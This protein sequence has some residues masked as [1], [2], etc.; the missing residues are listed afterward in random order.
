MF[1]SSGG[2]KGYCVHGKGNAHTYMLDFTSYY[3]TT[4]F[5][6]FVD[7][8]S[9][10]FPL[11]NSVHVDSQQ[12]SQIR[13]CTSYLEYTVPRYGTFG[14]DGIFQSDTKLKDNIKDTKVNALDIIKKLKHIQFDWKDTKM[15]IGKGHEKIG[16]SANQIQDD[17]GMNIVYEVKQPKESDFE[18]IKQINDSRLTPI[19]TKAIQELDDKYNKKIAELEEKISKLEG[20]NK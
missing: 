1:A 6:L 2:Q 5:L 11:I 8:I 18:S 13:H 14:I 10:P 15:A 12:I 17:I 20:G 3:G 19:I 7:G 16:Y 4:Y 9:N